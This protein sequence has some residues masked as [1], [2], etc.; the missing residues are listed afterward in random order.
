MVNQKE[1]HELEII[2]LTD[3]YNDKLDKANKKIK[4]KN[5][6]L[7]ILGTSTTISIILALVMAFADG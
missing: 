7:I 4:I 2:E 5:T 6:G 3:K 1:I